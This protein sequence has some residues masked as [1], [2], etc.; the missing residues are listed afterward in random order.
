V[1][2]PAALELAALLALVPVKVSAL[3]PALQPALLE[4]QE[5]VELLRVIRWGAVRE[6]L[7]DP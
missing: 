7:R 2:Q 6:Q 5:P 3:V 1:Q 4:L